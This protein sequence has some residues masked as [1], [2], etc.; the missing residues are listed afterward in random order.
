MGFIYRIYCTAT[1]QNYVGQTKDEKRRWAEHIKDLRTGKH[2][3]RKLQDVFWK[4]GES[5]LQ[6]EI[7]E[8]NVDADNMTNREA[9]WMKEHK[10]YGDGLNVAYVGHPNGKPDV[11]VAA[12]KFG[13]AP[14][15][16]TIVQDNKP[17]PFGAA[18]TSPPQAAPVTLSNTAA[19]K[20]LDE[21]R[22]YITE[23]QTR[24]WMWFKEAKLLREENEILIRENAVLR[25][26][27]GER[28]ADDKAIA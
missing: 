4:H 22:D 23:Q 26:R 24:G 13:A 2:H 18:A 20:V 8:E 15:P 6:F 17:K 19:I 10:G 16:L 27:L 25:W 1:K 11:V 5:C 14:A 7:L 21:V 28:S 3:S 12:R 9:Y